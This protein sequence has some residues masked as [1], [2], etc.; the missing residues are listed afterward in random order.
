[1]FYYDALWILTNDLLKLCCRKLCGL[2]SSFPN[3][4]RNRH[5]RHSSFHQSSTQCPP[6]SP[7]YT[8]KLFSS[9]KNQSPN[10]ISTPGYVTPNKASPTGYLDPA[11]NHRNF[12]E[13]PQLNHFVNEDK[14]KSSPHH[15]KHRHREQDQARAMAQVVKWLEQEVFKPSPNH[16]SKSKHTEKHTTTKTTENRAKVCNSDKH[17]HHH[18]HEHVH[19]HYHHYNESPV[20]V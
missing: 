12:N 8:N 5:K 1:M 15:L 17:E 9:N 10:N 11:A 20:L 3:H 18:I 4:H 6:F 2:D 7:Q 14:L 19:H 13:S 16:R